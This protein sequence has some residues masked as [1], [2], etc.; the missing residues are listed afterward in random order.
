MYY[1]YMYMPW[2]MEVCDSVHVDMLHITCWLAF[3]VMGVVG[4][5]AMKLCTFPVALGQLCK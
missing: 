5:N 3:I 4:T 1:M 2:Y